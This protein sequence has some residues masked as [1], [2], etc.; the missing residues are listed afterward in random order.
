MRAC[1]TLVKSQ[2][3]VGPRWH[4]WILYVLTLAKGRLP[5]G[6]GLGVPQSTTCS[7][8]V[9]S[10]L[11]PPFVPTALGGFLLSIMSLHSHH[12]DTNCRLLVYILSRRVFHLQRH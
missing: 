11:P 4:Q 9:S 10:Q 7:C 12:T 2:H 6:L 5:S 8:S 1:L 3:A